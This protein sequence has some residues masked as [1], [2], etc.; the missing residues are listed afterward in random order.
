ME[1]GKQFDESSRTSDFWKRQ[2]K[3]MGAMA[4]ICNDCW[5]IEYKI[6]VTNK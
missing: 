2:F 5:K 4:D 1:C 3:T 6:D